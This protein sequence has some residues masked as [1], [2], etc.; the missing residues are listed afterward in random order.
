[1]HD[2]NLLGQHWQY[3]GGSP[4]RNGACN[5]ATSGDGVPAEDASQRRETLRE[6]KFCD[7]GVCGADASSSGISGPGEG[8]RKRPARLFRFCDPRWRALLPGV[9]GMT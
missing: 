4:L 8:L 2:L 6:L 9:K 3:R 7:V 1:M 5:L